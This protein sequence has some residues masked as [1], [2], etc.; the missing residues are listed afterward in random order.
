V[1]VD[2]PS[3]DSQL[4]QRRRDWAPPIAERCMLAVMLD[5]SS[6]LEGAP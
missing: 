6:M 2:S 3:G 5:I 1:D 4:G